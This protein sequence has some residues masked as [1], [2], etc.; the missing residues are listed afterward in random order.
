MKKTML[1]AAID[2]LK[3]QIRAKQEALAVL[4]EQRAL[5]TPVRKPR[6]VAPL[7]SEKESA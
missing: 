1:D 5:L 6:A 3:D 2:N 7:L 4:E